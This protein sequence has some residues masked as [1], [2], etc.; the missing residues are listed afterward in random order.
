MGPGLTTAPARPP[1][2]T[3]PVPAQIRDAAVIYVSGKGGS[4]KTTVA[5]AIG[6]A[7]ARTGRRTIVCELAGA[8]RLPRAFGQA[9]A[10]GRE[11]PLA[12][13]LWAVG[14]DPEQ[15]LREWLRRQPGGAVADAVLGRSPAFAQFVAAAPG[16]KELVTIGKVLDLAG[17]SPVHVEERP[18]DLVVVDAAST[19]H[20]IGMAAAPGTVGNTAGTGAV[21]DQARALREVLS[22]PAATAYVGVSLSEEMSTREVLDLDRGLEDAIGRRLD[23]IVVNAVWP[24]RFSDAEA[25]RLSELDAEAGDRFPQLRAALTAHRR[26]RHDA[27]GVRWLRERAR[28]PVITFPYV[29]APTLGP[30]EYETLAAGL[31]AS[32][33]TIRVSSPEAGSLRS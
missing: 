11:T 2:A 29:F 26:A 3:A 21:G 25:S 23:L 27:A 8:D 31:T 7:A 30:A 10:Y 1:S 18:F 4:G 20:A 28:C 15:A 9:P 24:D 5:A 22:D 13:C 12:P 32:R 19:G 6:L 33:T 14:I 16:A 17:R